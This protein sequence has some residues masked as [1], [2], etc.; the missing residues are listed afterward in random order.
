[1]SRESTTGPAP[2]TP[3]PTGPCGMCPCPCRPGSPGCPRS[4]EDRRGIINLTS[5]NW[6]ER[7]GLAALLLPALVACGGGQP[8]GLPQFLH[9]LPAVQG[10]QQVDVAGLAVQY[11][12]RQLALGHEHPRRLLVRIAAI[13]EFHRISHVLCPPVYTRTRK[14]TDTNPGPAQ[15]VGFPRCAPLG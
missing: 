2:W 10:V 8:G 1:M 13:F 15:T 3:L 5:M 7:L 9:Q 14:K 12:E 6:I 11:G 4:S